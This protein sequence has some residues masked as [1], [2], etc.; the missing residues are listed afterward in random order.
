MQVTILGKA[1]PHLT[2]QQQYVSSF[3]VTETAGIPPANLP[4]S[5]AIQSNNAEVFSVG[6]KRKALDDQ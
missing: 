2:A 5:Q 3:S 6:R 4:A 1:F